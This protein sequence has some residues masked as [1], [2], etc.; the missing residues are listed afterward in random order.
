M[1]SIILNRTPIAKVASAAVLTFSLIT[2]QGVL[3]A[4]LDDEVPIRMAVVETV[5]KERSWNGFKK[6]LEEAGIE[7]TE[8]KKESSSSIKKVAVQQTTLAVKNQAPYVAGPSVADPEVQ[9]RVVSY[10]SD[11]PEMIY[12]AECE[13]T[14]RQ[15]E[16]SGE[17]LRGRAVS[18]DVG[19]MQVNEYYHLDRS[20][21]LGFDIHTLEG[22]LGYARVLYEEQGLQPW[23]ASR[24]CWAEKQRVAGL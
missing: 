2:Q 17:V 11:I 4:S 16:V 9:S 24:G 3:G 23:N 7:I 20:R 10:F 21:S 19:V 5:E 8:A 22:N 15:Y 18:A 12:V 14:F 1:N 6:Q 13:S